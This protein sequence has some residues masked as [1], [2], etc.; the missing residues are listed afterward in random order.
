M[1]GPSVLCKQ[2]IKAML[3]RSTGNSLTLLARQKSDRFG[4]YQPATAEAVTTAA[5]HRP[6]KVYPQVTTHFMTVD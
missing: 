3:Q 5:A 6:S 1:D 2:E 4:F